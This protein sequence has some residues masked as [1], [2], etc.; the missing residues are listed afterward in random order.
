[1]I[2]GNYRR[3]LLLSDGDHTIFWEDLIG[4]GLLIAAAAFVVISL[5]REFRAAKTRAN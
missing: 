1:M 4:R 2:E 5:V 3:S